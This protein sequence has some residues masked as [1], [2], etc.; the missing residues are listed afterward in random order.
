MRTI[1]FVEFMNMTGINASQWNIPVEMI[2]DT[3]DIT[4]H[5]TGLEL[6]IKF[7]EKHNGVFY[8]T[9]GIVTFIKN[10]NTTHAAYDRAM[11]VVG[12]RA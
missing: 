12:K 5:E 8:V 9:D 3:I 1:K 10:P 4:G 11:G 7:G 6:V 2:N